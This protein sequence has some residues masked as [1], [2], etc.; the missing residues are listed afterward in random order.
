M[1]LLPVVSIVVGG[2]AVWSGFELR[3]R[4]QRMITW[5]SVRGSITGSTVVADGTFED[6][7]AAYY[8]QIQYRYVVAGQEYAG[9]RRSLVNVGVGRFLQAGPRKIV[10]QYP[11]GSEVVVFYDPANPREAILDRP[12]PVVGPT[13][14]CVF[15]ATLA[16]GVPLWGWLTAH[17]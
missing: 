16:I 1:S 15:G 5:P 17:P 11:V 7:S 9:Q 6:G 4:A 14:L 2:A 12:E 8:P 13:L 3:D 10:E